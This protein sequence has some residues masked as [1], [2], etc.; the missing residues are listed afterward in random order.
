MECDF[1]TCNLESRVIDLSQSFTCRRK[2]KDSSRKGD[3]V[4]RNGLCRSSIWQGGEVGK[5]MVLVIKEYGSVLQV[6]VRY[7]PY[8]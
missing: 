3:P 5:G 1:D 2:R 8:D 7:S 6:W 4:K